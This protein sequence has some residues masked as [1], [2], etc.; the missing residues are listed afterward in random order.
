MDNAN[1][2]DN[3]YIIIPNP[4]YDVVFRYLMA[5][6]ESALIV[7]STLINEKIKKLHLEPLTHP[8]KKE[9]ISK[10]KD[11]KTEDDVRLFHLDFTATI[12]LADGTEELIMIELQKASEPE[13]IFR[14]KRYISKNFQQKNIV[15]LTDP[16][17]QAIKVVER[18]IRLIPIFILNF[19]IENEVN[20]LLIKINRLKIGVFKNETLKKHNEFIDNL[21]Y[22]MLVVQLPNLHNIKE[23]EYLQDEYKKKLYALLKLFD[24]K[25]QVKN[26]E[27]RLRLIRKMLPGFLDRVIARLQAADSEN[28]DLE[29]NMFIEDEI[30]KILIDRDNT[31][32]FFQEKFELTKEQ[33]DT[34][35]EQLDTTKEQLDTTKEQLDTTKEQLDQVL[36]EKNELVL[37]IAKKLKAEGMSSENIQALTG[38][39]SEEINGI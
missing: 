29:E 22:D 12:E 2:N 35:K 32:A 10:V 5:D 16:R 15:E 33:L 17:T 3:E 38:L 25:E 24:Q 27:H 23:E 9:P 14:F 7:L 39:S 20:D 8:E 31:I 30:L 1:P 4:I 26:N 11:P 37:K 28:P 19:R 34:T 36:Q 18:P 6:Y 21:S 13:D